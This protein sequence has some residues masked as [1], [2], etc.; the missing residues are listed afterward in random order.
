MNSALSSQ[1][2]S[3][4][5][6]DIRLIDLYNHN[7]VI[8]SVKTLIFCGNFENNCENGFASEYLSSNSKE[9]ILQKNSK[10][11]FT[12]RKVWVEIL[13]PVLRAF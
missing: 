8:S 11:A 10:N 12:S 6:R 7:C 1:K 9:L 13:N 3:F 4:T 5:E 2:D